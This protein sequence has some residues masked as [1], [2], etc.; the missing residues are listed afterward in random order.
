MKL[1]TKIPKSNYEE[2]VDAQLK[3][4]SILHLLAGLSAECGEVNGIYQKSIYKQ[5]V[6]DRQDLLSELGDVLFY[7]TALANFAGFT[8]LEVQT[9]NIIKLHKRN[10]Q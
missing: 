3:D 10:G 1:V 4:K 2:F 8:L 6:V 9:E 5:Q 7:L